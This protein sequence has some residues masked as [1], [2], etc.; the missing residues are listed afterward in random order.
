MTGSPQFN[1]SLILSG[2]TILLAPAL[3]ADVHNAVPQAYGWHELPDTRLVDQCPPNNFAGYG[4]NF[5]SACDN[6]TEAWGGAGYDSGRNRMYIWGGGHADYYGNELYAL[7]LTTQQMVRLTDPG[8]P[9]DPDASPA[10]SELA[11]HDGTQPHSRH[12]YDGITYIDHA[13][14][15]WAFSGSLASKVGSGDNVTWLFDPNTNAWTRDAHSG[16]I[17]KVVFA[18]FAAYDPI[19]EKVFFHDRTALY[20]YTYAPD[21]GVYEKLIN[22]GAIGLDGNA[23]IDPINRK[24]LVIGRGQQIIYDLDP[25]GGYTRTDHPPA[26]DAGF[27]AHSGPGLAYDANAGQ[28]VAWIGDGKIYYLD[29]ATMTWSSLAM[30]GGPGPQHSQGTYG[31][32]AY[33]AETDAFVVVGRSEYNATTFKTPVG[34]MD[35]TPPTS[36]ANLQINPPYPLSVELSWDPATDNFGIAGYRVYVDGVLSSDQAVT[37]YKAMPLAPQQ[38]YEFHVTA[39][40]SSGNESATSA[41]VSLTTATA[42]TAPGLGDCGAEVELVGRSDVVFCE[43]WEAVD[44]YTEGYLSDPIVADP[45]ALLSSHVDRTEI[46]DEDCVAGK[47]LKAWMNE[48]DTGTLSAY[49]PLAHAGLAPDNIYL[50][51][52]LKL[53]DD[54]DGNMCDAE[55]GITGFGGKFPGPADL[56]TWADPTGQCGNGGA[57]G[58]GINCWSMRTNYASCFSSNG[59][60]CATKPNAITRLGSYL[61]YGGQEGGTGD[62]AYWDADDWGQFTGDGGS[63]D[64]VAN[65]VYCGRG[66]GGV[67]ER[68]RWYQIETQ[69]GMNTLGEADGVIRAWVDGVLSY[70]KTNMI[71]R[72]PGHDFLHNRLIWLN[73]YKGGVDG[74][75]ATTAVYLDQMVV[76]LDAP[77]GGIDFTTPQPPDLTLTVSSVDV[78]SG[79]SVDVSWGSSQATSCTASGLWQGNKALSGIEAVG[80]LSASGIMRLDCDG[81]GGSV[82]RQ[83]IVI[84]DGIPIGGT[85]GPG[86]DTE[87]PS[88][89]MNLALEI[90]DTDTLL[91]T[92]DASS[93]DTAVM[94]YRVYLGSVLVSP[95]DDTEYT[96][97][98][99][100]PGVTVEY[101][102]T[103]IDQAGNVSALSDPISITLPD[104]GGGQ[105]GTLTLFPTSDTFLALSTTTPRGSDPRIDVGSTRTMLLQFPVELVAPEFELASAKLQI[106]S[107]SEFGN[108]DISVYRVDKPWHE[109]VATHVYADNSLQLAWNNLLGDWIDSAGLAQGAVA[110]ASAALVDDNV[111]NTTELDITALVRGWLNGDFDNHG[112]IIVKTGGNGVNQVFRSTNSQDPAMWPRLVIEPLPGQQDLVVKAAEDTF[113]TTSTYRA[114][115]N[116]ASV[117]IGSDRNL[118]VKFPTDDILSASEIEVATLRLFTTFE[119]G[120]LTNVAAFSPAKPW[121]E[122]AAT[123]QYADLNSGIA[124]DQLNGDWTDASGVM[125][126][127]D[128][129]S[130]TYLVDDNVLDWVEIDVTAL[131]RDWLSGVAP[132]SH[133]IFLISLGS[134]NFSFRSLQNGLGSEFAPELLLRY[135]P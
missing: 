117:Y 127:L 84:V 81:S 8:A 93:D 133:G 21:G 77:I 59:N 76:A 78:A 31:R 44:W 3:S 118:L 124:W 86:A 19:S 119:G 67:L 102:V 63:C 50:R 72:D 51:Y 132:A 130:N 90:I 70:E 110:Y 24:M 52:Y 1:A 79:A 104:E 33:V 56:R 103:A 95:V 100:P 123:R 10:E 9:A 22:D 36:P 29:A 121:R 65:N 101:T 107:K 122:L 15:L 125:H 85:G 35:A 45:R 32:F 4:Y 57:R 12:T 129:Y 105:T 87:P 46:V 94:E 43:P 113:V 89:P 131:V 17:P 25:A 53:A 49:W 47:C 39:Y 30:N 88:V 7:D 38:T 40:D 96:Q 64:T 128:A 58:D 112:M 28:F 26:G 98:N 11:P 111:S 20:T 75:C 41:T 71:F 109:S 14:R 99:L 120:H 34:V 135:R 66:D 134:G 61:Y 69:V 2:L 83:Q 37:A 48:G 97:S 73:I 91:L 116:L 6:V 80:P 106:T 27:L 18:A 126:G 13:D 92:W 5:A 74:N 115:G 114:L 68:G 42:P 55:G 54:W 62:G 60:A 82:A 16:D 108:M 23:A